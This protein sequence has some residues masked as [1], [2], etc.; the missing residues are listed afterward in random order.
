MAEVGLKVE[1]RTGRGKGPARQ[2]R[3]AGGIPAVLYGQ[4]QDS[5]ALAVN[6]RALSHALATEAGM[7][8]LLDL[9][10]DGASELAMPKAVHR[11]PVKG[12]IIHVDFLRIN[13]L[14]TITVDIPLHIEGTSAG[15]KLG[16]ML[17]IHLHS[18]HIETLPSNVPEAL[19]VDVTDLNVGDT[20]RV[21][22]LPV[23]DG[24]TVLNPADDIVVACIVA[25]ELPTEPELEAGA[26]E[27]IGETPAEGDAASTEA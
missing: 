16:G 21:Q 23:P 27:V 4:G 25:L 19:I 6:E 12:H 3:I 22:D 11:D 26:T 7:N 17:D 5:L 18:V 20:L 10:V 15:V 24:V 14:Q 2:L 1:V 8:V 13:R 9:Q